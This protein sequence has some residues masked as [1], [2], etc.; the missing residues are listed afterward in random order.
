MYVNLHVNQVYL[1]YLAD[2]GDFLLTAN[3]LGTPD[4]HKVLFFWLLVGL[5]SNKS[6]HLDARAH[7]YIHTYIIH[8]IGL[9]KPLN[10]FNININ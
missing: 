8:Y 2:L 10:T 3:P 6:V 5:A 9:R 4:A 7:I 1:Y